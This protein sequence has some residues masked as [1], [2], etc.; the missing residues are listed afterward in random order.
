MSAHCQEVIQIC[1][2][3]QDAIPAGIKTLSQ[4]LLLSPEITLQLPRRS[5]SLNRIKHLKEHTERTV[6]SVIEDRYWRACQRLQDTVSQEYENFRASGLSIERFGG[7]SDTEKQRQVAQGLSQRYEQAEKS[8][9]NM[10]IQRILG[11]G[12]SKDLDGRKDKKDS[13]RTVSPLPLIITQ[14]SFP[15]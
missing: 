8:F 9:A 12:E 4:C 14:P 7:T 2:N 3:I 10:I 5:T 1:Q 6:Y 15:R 11:N 13:S